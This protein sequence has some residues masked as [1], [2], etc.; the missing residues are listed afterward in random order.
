MRSRVLITDFAILT[1][2][3]K[4]AKRDSRVAVTGPGL[5]KKKCSVVAA[6]LFR[7]IREK[8]KHKLIDESP[9][10]SP[11]TVAIWQKTRVGFR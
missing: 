10:M 6:S 7:V 1:P 2:A 8:R 3:G 4:L 9:N 5:L 11:K